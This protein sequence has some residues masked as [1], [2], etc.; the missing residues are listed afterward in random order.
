M[1]GFAG[2]EGFNLPLIVRGVSGRVGPDSELR[3]GCSRRRRSGTCVGE[4]IGSAR[5]GGGAGMVE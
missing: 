5:F 1:I 3:Y 4:C 2:L